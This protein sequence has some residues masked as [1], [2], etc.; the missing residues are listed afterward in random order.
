MRRIFAL[1]A[2]MYITLFGFNSIFRAEPG[3]PARHFSA[4]SMNY[5]DVARNILLNRGIVQ[6]TLGFNQRNFSAADPIPAPLVSQPPLYP[7]AIALLA[8]SGV[9]IA[10]AALLVSTIA[11]GLVLFLAFHLS[12]R[13]YDEQVASLA[14]AALILYPPLHEAARFA[15]SETLGLGVTLLALIFLLRA[16]RAPTGSLAAAAVA[17]VMT[18]LA[19]ATRYAL[20]PLLL[21]SVVFLLAEGRRTIRSLR[22]LTAYLLGFTVPAGLVLARNLAV[23]GRLLPETI[24]STTGVAINLL[25]TMGALLGH[26]G[27][28]SAPR[29]PEVLALVVFLTPAVALAMRPRQLRG[30]RAVLVGGPRYLLLLWSLGYLT[31]LLYLRTRKHFDS[32]EPRLILPGGATLVLLWAALALQAL[33]MRGRSVSGLALVV[34]ALAIGREG[35]TV[36][37][38]SAYDGRRVIASSER[39]S[40]ILQHT[41]DRD[42]VIGENAVE[43][44]FFFGHRAALSYSSY[45]TTDYLTYQGLLDYLAAHGS[46]YER[47]YV[48][49]ARHP[50]REEEWAA[51]YG[52]FVTD[53][54]FGPTRGYPCIVPLARL[55]DGYVFE[56]CCPED[57]T[58]SPRAPCRPLGAV[59][60]TDST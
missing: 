25:R 18:G 31:A 23:C 29:W 36:A 2:L 44:P 33:P 5:V 45:P 41:T 46:E 8:L 59:S 26:S 52:P 53:L 32:I 1:A 50:M 35:Y 11:Y 54:I 39:L 13:L 15:W 42:L 30:V 9:Q 24:P 40:W 6:S 27:G 48:A 38:W 3:F 51:A 4:D 56:I 16:A 12:R 49:V 34:V 55:Q 22:A 19:F 57:R 21:A 20:S 37:S 7:L 60:P 14:V 28:L 43:I 17:G 58:F 10:E 47:V